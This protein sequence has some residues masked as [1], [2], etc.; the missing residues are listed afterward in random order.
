MLKKISNEY[1]KNW[2]DGK[3][4]RTT[5]EEYDSDTPIIDELENGTTAVQNIVQKVTLPIIEEGVDL[6]RAEAAAKMAQVSISDCRYFLT[7]IIT[8]SNA[9]LIQKFIESILFLY[10]YEGKKTERDIRSTYFITWD[11]SL[12][13][14]TNSK[15]PNINTINDIL[16]TWSENSGIN[17]KFSRIAS[18]INY[19]KAIFYYLILCIQKHV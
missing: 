3:A 6:V 8:D 10:I 12:F 1:M 7:L 2:K 19:K 13:K 16:N 4:A 9:D 17:K 15:N 18:R 11:A 14:K 5:N